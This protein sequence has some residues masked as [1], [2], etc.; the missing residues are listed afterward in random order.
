VNTEEGADDV[1]L[2]SPTGNEEGMLE[3]T[4]LPV[5]RRRLRRFRLEDRA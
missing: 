2:D 1:R 3:S 5:F 4:E